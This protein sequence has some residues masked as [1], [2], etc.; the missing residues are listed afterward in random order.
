METQTLPRKLIFCAFFLNLT[1]SMSACTKKESSTFT[2]P[3]PPQ[4][5]SGSK[6]IEQHEDSLNPNQLASFEQNILAQI[7]QEHGPHNRLQLSQLYF[8]SL[9]FQQKENP[10]ERNRLAALALDDLLPRIAD[11]QKTDLHWGEQLS[12][13]P[14][15]VLASLSEAMD[16]VQTKGT[17]SL[18]SLVVDSLA[19]LHGTFCST[20]YRELVKTVGPWQSTAES[21]LVTREQ[22]LLQ[23]VVDHFQP[24]EK[25]G[26]SKLNR[27]FLGYEAVSL[28]GATQ[29]SLGFF[30]DQLQRA[31]ATRKDLER[32]GL[33]E[34]NDDISSFES[35]NEIHFESP[36][37]CA[38]CDEFMQA[39]NRLGQKGGASAVQ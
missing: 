8:R 30:T 20:S 5:Q 38:A 3:S 15:E 39:L 4:T 36:K 14:Q 25:S 37:D 27:A 18:Y 19:I 11:L 10:Q 34:A 22:A 7:F 6:P 33:Q 31:Y 21:L 29:D 16:T 9:A 28:V 23:S 13:S 32:L 12:I 2:S 35:L 1:L 26:F 17:P 24:R